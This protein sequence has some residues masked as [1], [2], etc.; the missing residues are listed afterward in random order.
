M[1]IVTS[2]EAGAY[3]SVY[4]VLDD[5]C[6]ARGVP[7][8]SQGALYAAIDGLRREAAPSEHIALAERIAV[9]I[10]RLLWA[11][12]NGE[13]GEEETVREELQTLGASWLQIPVP[14]TVH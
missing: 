1:T 8:G 3:L 11:L 5:V 9:A 13:D 12:K 7:V 2:R 14:S 6:F 10:H 4:Q